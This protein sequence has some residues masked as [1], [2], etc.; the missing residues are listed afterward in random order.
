[1]PTPAIVGSILGTAVGDALGLPYEGLSRRRGTRLFGEPDRY[2]FLFGRGM[3]SDD[4]DHTCLVA[5]AL[6]ASGGDVDRFR[7]RLAGLMR[8][9]LLTVPAG[10]GRATL[11]A[12]VKLWLGFPPHR[13]GVFSAGNGPAMRSAVLGSALDD[14]D[15]L[16]EFVRAS[17]R[18][19]HTDPKAEF[20]AWAVALAA[21]TAR[22]ANPVSGDDYLEC[23]RQSLAGEPAEEFLG[24]VGRAVDSAG[25]G[26][27]TI[28]FADSL[29]LR[30][31]VSGYV[32][33]TVPVALHAW[34][35]HPRDFRSSVGSVIRCGGDTDTTAAIVGGMVG[36]AVGREGIPPEWLARLLGWPRTVAWMQ[37]LG[38][39]LGEALV[40]GDSQRP[41]QTAYLA[42]LARNGLFLATVLGHIG[43]RLLPPY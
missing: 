16:R 20:G 18:I 28:A 26:E 6:I 43:R 14:T 35:S 36:A 37:A 24:L 39:R 11:R 40:S 42:E 3:V 12:T 15:R 19:T 9:W 8:R 2:R 23:L 5:Q 21:H 29:G 25:R 30:R 13:S 34:L 7:R 27:S 38:E 1:M 22:R 10:I 32:Y 41:P 17:T 31:G 4:T 33:H